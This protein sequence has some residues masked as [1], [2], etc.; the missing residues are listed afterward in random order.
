MLLFISMYPWLNPDKCEI[1]KKFT[2]GVKLNKY[3]IHCTVNHQIYSIARLHVEQTS[4][5]YK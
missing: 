5:I 4:T 2:G 3:Y 1:W